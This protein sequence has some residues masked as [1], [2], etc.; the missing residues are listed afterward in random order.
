[1]AFLG[2][3]Y[4]FLL[5]VNIIFIIIWIIQK[6][7][8]FLISLLGIII[9]LDFLTNLVHIDFNSKDPDYSDKSIK[10]LSYNV[11]VFDLWS[12]SNEKNISNKIFHFIRNS[13]S[14]IVCLQ[15]F[16]SKEEQGKNAADSLLNH[17]VLSYSHIAY[18]I[19]DNRPTNY[20]IATFSSFPIVS[21]GEVKIRMEDNYC[22]Y[23]DIII[24][25]DTLRIYNIHLESIHLGEQDYQL[26]ENIDTEDT[27]D[28]KGL[29][30]I[31]WKFKKSYIK[32]AL[33]VNTIV[34][35]LNTC[36]YPVILCGDFNDTPYSYVYKQL[37]NKLTDAF[38]HSGNGTGNTYIN[39]YPAFRIDYILHSP[40]LKSFGFYSE[41]I[42]LS[43]HYPVQCYFIL[44]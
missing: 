33:Q 9:G 27:P 7:K 8:L 12:W 1:M 13:R 14:N 38:R 2:L 19:R 6:S 37:T 22:I 18:A 23:S 17:S 28:L 4:P 43:D 5:L 44:K 36:R 3:L 10:I 16:Y 26:I 21:K 11:R 39:K 41:K 42:K 15:E 31:Y 32:R 24:E 40:K 35:H 20:G 30:S 34:A 25:N 29:R